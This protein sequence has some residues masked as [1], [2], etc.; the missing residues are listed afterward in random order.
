MQHPV[1]F[2]GEPTP[3]PK[4]SPEGDRAVVEG[5]FAADELPKAGLQHAAG[6]GGC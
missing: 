5:V 3:H 6:R 1:L 2:V 4:H